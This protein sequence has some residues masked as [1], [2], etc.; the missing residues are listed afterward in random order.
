MLN[1]DRKFVIIQY[2]IEHAEE[3]AR[4]S[5]FYSDSVEELFESINN[6]KNSLE[7]CRVPNVHRS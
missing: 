7:A 2:L 6:L 5:C 3:M 4:G 1:V